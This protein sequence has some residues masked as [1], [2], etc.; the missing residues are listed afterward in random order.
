MPRVYSLT[1]TMMPM[2]ITL[3]KNL[4]IKNLFLTGQAINRAVLVY[5][6]HNGLTPDYHSSKSADR[7]S[8]SSREFKKTTTPTATAPATL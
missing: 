8:I 5:K 1:R 7:S 4:D 6:S 3:S 2:L